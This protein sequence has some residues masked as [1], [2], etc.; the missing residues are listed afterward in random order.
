MIENAAF[1]PFPLNLIL[2]GAGIAAVKG[3]FSNIPEFATG[4]NFAPGGMALVGERGPELINLPQGS[5]VTPSHQLGG[6][7]GGASIVVNGFVGNEFELARQIDIVLNN[8]S[9]NVARTTF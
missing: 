6:M 8:Q 3:L 1:L 4:T 2:A 9:G 7:G 5:K